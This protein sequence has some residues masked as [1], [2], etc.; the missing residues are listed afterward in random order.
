MSKIR[1]MEEIEIE[2]YHFIKDLFQEIK[3]MHP[4]GGLNSP[5]DIELTKEINKKAAIMDHM[6]DAMRV[7]NPGFEI[8][9]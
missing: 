5:R 2:L 3:D 6:Q 1:T 7:I 8:R 4:V 9:G